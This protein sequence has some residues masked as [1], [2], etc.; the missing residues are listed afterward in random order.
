QMWLD[1]SRPLPSPDRIV[2][3]AVD[4]TALWA[5][6]ARKTFLAHERPDL[7]QFG[8]VQ[9]GVDAGLRSESAEGRVAIGFD[10]YAGGGLSVGEQRS[11]MLP[12]L[13][14]ALA[15]LPEDRP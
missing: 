13:A 8:I 12:A 4:R 10:G 2:R 5:E 14:A 9:G 7:S 6:R 1:V 11:E 15:G 3:S